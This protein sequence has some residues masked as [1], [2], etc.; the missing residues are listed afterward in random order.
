MSA[1]E[2]I[3]PVLLAGGS[4][5][6]LW[7]VSRDDMPKQF[8]PLTGE[9][10]SYQETCKRVSDK[11]LFAEPLVITNET[12]RF[13]ARRQAESVGT[14]PLVV[15]EPA[16]R[17]SA[18]AVA[19]AAVLAERQNPG[20]LV[21]ALAADHIVL[22]NDLFLAAVSRGAEA[23]RKGRIV[24]FGLTPT[25]PRTSFGYISPG[26]P[27]YG[28]DDLFE[29]AKF[30]EKPDH[31][32]AMGYVKD[33]YLWNSGN[34]LFRSDVMIAE[35]QK[36]APEILKAVTAA[37]DNGAEDLG[38]LRLEK[39]AFEQSPA[40][41]IDYA[42][43][44]KASSIAVVAGKFRWSDIGS[45]D[46]IW[47]V[48]PR[49]EADNAVLGAALLMDT[50]GSL[51]QSQ[52]RL[53][54]VIGMEDVIVISTE[55]AV[56]VAPKA[57]AQKVKGLVESLKD[58]GHR[59]ASLHPGEHRPWGSFKTLANGERYHV[60]RIT[61]NP[62]GI[63]SLQ[64]HFHRAEHWIVVKGTAE[65]TCGEDIKIVHENESVYLPLGV[66]HRLANPGKIPLEVIEVQTGSYFGEDDIVRLEDIY[67]RK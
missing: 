49:D 57:Q 34:F 20:G 40:I 38:F 63:L 8:Q 9:L 5:S 17:D 13:F 54:T 7:P 18:A 53:T 32:T 44:E 50:R 35:F 42:V 47:E 58:A 52:D 26:K 46:A 43:I 30:V 4:G 11:Q 14:K 39:T 3:V 23:A 2:R 60:K 64:K 25:E 12:F 29:V 22:D 37:V 10:S 62:G 1:D 16:R 31:G 45:W 27:L 21:L 55:D 41:S 67:S 66:V 15:L 19:A 51:V 65:V 28:H 59:E 24:V 56:M 6:R 33:G 36:N 48:T 61:V